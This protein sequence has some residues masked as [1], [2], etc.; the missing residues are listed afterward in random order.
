MPRQALLIVNAKSRSGKAALPKVIEGLRRLDIVPVH[1]ECASREELSSMIVKKGANAEALIQTR[2]DSGSD[3]SFADI[4]P[5]GS[6]VHR[7]LREV[8]C[9]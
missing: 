6:P 5:K 1:G 2:S 9:E 7:A 3:E 4:S 8:A